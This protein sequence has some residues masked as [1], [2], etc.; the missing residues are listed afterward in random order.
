LNRESSPPVAFQALLGFGGA[1]GLYL[2]Q[3]RQVRSGD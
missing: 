1:L 2:H 3:R